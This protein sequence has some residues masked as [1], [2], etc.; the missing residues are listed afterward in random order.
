M[1][2]N[3]EIAHFTLVKDRISI[4]DKGTDSLIIE[5]NNEQVMKISRLDTEKTMLQEGLI[6]LYINSRSTEKIAPRIFAFTKHILL[7]EKINGYSLKEIVK[8]GL[9]SYLTKTIIL[10]AL[11]KAVFL[12]KIGVSHNEL[13]RPYKHLLI[14]YS[15]KEPII[16]DFGSSSI[17]SKPNNFTQLLSAFFFTNSL[18]S[19]TIKK[20]LDINNEKIISLKKAAIDYKKSLDSNKFEKVME[21]L[22]ELL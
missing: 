1:I 11:K 21:T 14:E 15:T 6:L 19:Q 7:M 12:D 17:T 5:V 18:L 4:K 9:N 10:K 22:S 20:Q 3:K 2:I 8:R 13:S 16:I